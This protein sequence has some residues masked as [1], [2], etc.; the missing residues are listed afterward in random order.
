MK[1]LYRIVWAVAFLA[2]IVSSGMTLAFAPYM[3][4]FSILAMC[5]LASLRPKEA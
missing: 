2:A 3:A 1:K 5:V 4:P